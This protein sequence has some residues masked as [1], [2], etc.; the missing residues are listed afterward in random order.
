MLKGLEDLRQKVIWAEWDVK[1]VVDKAKEL[2]PQ[3]DFITKGLTK[4]IRAEQSANETPF[5][6]DNYDEKEED[7]VEDDGTYIFIFVLMNNI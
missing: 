3:L 2:L 1:E 7:A 4:M 5:D 6:V